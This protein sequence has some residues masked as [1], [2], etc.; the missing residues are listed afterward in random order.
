ML[1]KATL[2]ENLVPVNLASRTA[3]FRKSTGALLCSH[4]IAQL[5]F[6]NTDFIFRR[7]SSKTG[8]KDWSFID[9]S[10]VMPEIMLITQA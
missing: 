1:K 6:F 4:L 10:Y 5:A 7:L 3:G 8:S 2:L 9:L